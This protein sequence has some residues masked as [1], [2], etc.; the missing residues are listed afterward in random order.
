MKKVIRITMPD[1]SIWDVP[2]YIIAA[3]RATIFAQS[4]SNGDESLFRTI[5]KAEFD[6]VYNDDIELI[7]W[8]QNCMCWSDIEYAAERIDYKGDLDYDYGWRNGVIQVINKE[9]I[10]NNLE[11]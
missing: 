6:S 1:S 2:A 7:N 11:G 4:D 9:E 5:F 10:E 8:A 3:H